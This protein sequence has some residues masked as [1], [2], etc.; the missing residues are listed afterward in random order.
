[1]RHQGLDNR[2]SR[3]GRNGPKLAP[4]RH[5]SVMGTKD[6]GSAHSAAL[7]TLRPSSGWACRSHAGGSVTVAG[8]RKQ[9]VQVGPLAGAVPVGGRTLE[10]RR[11]A[12]RPDDRK[13]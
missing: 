8:P 10:V 7:K 13:P 6:R 12:R 9:L 1:M 4:K 2:W 3:E 5:N 11:A